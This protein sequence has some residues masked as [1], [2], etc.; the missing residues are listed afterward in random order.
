MNE[1][2]RDMDMDSG[3]QAKTAAKK[4]NK[5]RGKDGIDRGKDFSDGMA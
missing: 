5:H 1:K 4:A 3:I 2:N